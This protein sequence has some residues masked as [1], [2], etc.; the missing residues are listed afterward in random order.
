[1]QIE[2][3][4]TTQKLIYCSFCGRNQYQCGVLISTPSADIC[5][6][7]ITALSESVTEEL[8]KRSVRDGLRQSTI[9]QHLPILDNEQNH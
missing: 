2:S 3:V 9:T 7:C 1:M 5:N 6:H 4:T 8:I